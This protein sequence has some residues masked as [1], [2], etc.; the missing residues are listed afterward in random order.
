MG[1]QTHT[2]IH[3]GYNHISAESIGGGVLTLSHGKIKK[4]LKIGGCIFS[5]VSCGLQEPRHTKSRRLSCCIVRLRSKTKKNHHSDQLFT[6]AQKYSTQT[7]PV[8]ERGLWK[9][10]SPK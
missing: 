8:K 3:K 10:S 4:L 1:K 9:N 7:T 5:V 2:Y 6:K